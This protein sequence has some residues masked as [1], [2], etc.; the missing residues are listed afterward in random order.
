MKLVIFDVNNAACSLAVCPNGYSYT[1]GCVFVDCTSSGAY[2]GSEGHRRWSTGLLFDNL[3]ELD[4]PRPGVNP[5]LLGL[6]NRG[7]YGTS[8]GWQ[9][10]TEKFLG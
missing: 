3:I 5:R 2:A 7:Y 4:G 10:T 6:Y 9:K 8:H 1:S